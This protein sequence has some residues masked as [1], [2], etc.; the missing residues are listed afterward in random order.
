M[1]SNT[2]LAMNDTPP[3]A[4]SISSQRRRKSRSNSVSSSVVTVK[5][6]ASL[7]SRASASLP[8]TSLSDTAPTT[9]DFAKSSSRPSASRRRSSVAHLAPEVY[10]SYKD[11]NT[12]ASLNRWSQS[13]TS[14]RS[15]GNHVHNGKLALSATI[16]HLPFEQPL[17]S[18][19]R[20]P[21]SPS[22]PSP[23]SSPR[24]RHRT[25]PPPIPTTSAR[26]L[27]PLDTLP[28]LL[29]NVYVPYS[30]STSSMTPSTTSAP[31]TP[32]NQGS[33]D[34]FST[35]PR[36][37]QS[38]L[39]EKTKPHSRNQ[40]GKSLGS[41]PVILSAAERQLS[42]RPPPVPASSSQ[43]ARDAAS[44]IPRSDSREK[45]IYRPMMDTT[46]STFPQEEY[47]MGTPPRVKER[48]D[49]DKKTMLS[50][51]LQKANTAVLLD[52]A[53]N[54]EGAMDA[55]QDACHL[56]QQVMIRSNGEEDRKKLEAIRVTYTNR[57]EELRQLDPSYTSTSG[58]ALPNRPMSNESVDSLGAKSI[59]FNE[60][61]D[62]VIQTAT[63]T[64]IIPD[65]SILPD[66]IPERLSSKRDPRESTFTS[67]M[68]EVERSIPDTDPS[69]FLLNSYAS[70]SLTNRHQAL[71]PR[72]EHT[73]MPPPLSPHPQFA[74][75]FDTTTRDSPDMTSGRRQTSESTRDISR[76]QQ[77]SRENSEESMTWLDTIDES[78]SSCGSSVHSVDS[79]DGTR[80]RKHLHTG[81]NGTE[82]E[83][84]AA[85]DAAVEAAY[86]EGFE[87]YE[88][89]EHSLPRGGSV[90]AAMRK[91]EIAKEKV[92]ELERE[93]AI[94]A[95]S[96]RARELRLGDDDRGGLPAI[97]QSVDYG[98]DIDVDA[99]Q[100]EEMLEEMTKEFML[101]GF[102]FDLQSK[103]ALPRE[104]DSSGISGST[105]N[106][107]RSSKRTT[108]G[109][110][111]TTHSSMSSK[112]AQPPPPD[113]K[114]PPPPPPPSMPQ[115]SANSASTVRNRRLSGK[116]AGQLKIDTSV[117]RNLPAPPHT[118]QLTPKH[119]D[120]DPTIAPHPRSAQPVL[121]HHPPPER[122]APTPNTIDQA[123]R[124]TPPIVPA[125]SPSEPAA[126]SPVASTLTRVQSSEQTMVPS[127]PTSLKGSRGGI[128]ALRKN[129]SSL[130]LRNRALSISSPD[131]SD[132]SGHTPLSSTF[133]NISMRKQSNAVPLTP[134][135]PGFS[136][137]PLISAGIQ[138]FEADIHS[139][140]SPGSPN[141]M[142][143]NAPIP[144]EP[145]PDSYLLRPFWLMRCF[146][147]TIAHPR[148][149][150]LSTKLF[151]PRDVWSVK[152]VKIKATEE[153][154][155]NCDLLTAALMKLGSVDTLD[156]D[157]V[158]EEMQGLEVIL[159]Q[160]QNNLSKKLGSEVGVGGINIF[161]KDA[162]TVG[163]GAATGVDTVEPSANT[164]AAG[165]KSKN[166][167]TSWRKLRSKPSGVGL[168]LLATKDVSKDSLT[169]SSLPMTSLPNI[170]FTKRDISQV[171]FNG[172]NALYMS[173]LAK[174]FD[175]VQVVDR[176]ARQVEDPGL[177][178][179]SQTHVGLELSTRHAAEFFGFYICRFV[180]T[181]LTTMLDKF[182]KR[183]SEWVLV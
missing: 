53:Q 78:G 129:K 145:C 21:S 102:D 163:N 27:P 123:L 10:T 166:Y 7:N 131:G 2:L 182:I 1:Y 139:P 13:T 36:P 90:S 33:S 100:D 67:A 97:R 116:T 128:G 60:N 22:R 52:N 93:E 20:P 76:K 65:S 11:H 153:K 92:L 71:D 140:Y 35:K 57:I 175:A 173:S 32:N 17:R 25:S 91:V 104:S 59:F 88:A 154:I 95:A 99:N 18:P 152:G 143:I 9:H 80:R 114:P 164:K 149:G 133:S 160:V 111:Q 151:V 177:K 119:D 134:M 170:R 115:S 168:S 167:L 110:S 117:H 31:Y 161:F 54:F 147:Q 39:A 132:I 158:L 66:P 98:Y 157:A 37:Q 150:Y 79:Q 30:A 16:T 26:S 87:P 125:P 126:N 77:H 24:R 106:S 121:H 101:D 49:K 43:P 137:E 108:A 42:Q 136:N 5:R 3:P 174:L 47:P 118:E 51:A 86:D 178:H 70:S 45:N 144:L 103:S 156:A 68:R 84:N 162:T 113:K 127:S 48:R 180:L 61:D 124:A 142:A 38:S 34:Y 41:S 69:T 29:P 89:G 55:Y 135:F 105:W 19:P 44:R 172:P 40:T 14:S 85:L 109:Q 75:S 179:S 171:D 183:G 146:Y 138:L 122:Q 28:T 72:M 83:F 181:D 94:K 81:S 107:S 73:Y 130:S 6:S 165:D 74:A 64:R 63:L 56:L 176:V 12:A 46:G 120:F 62:A 141:P 96:L 23:T 169:M 58:K 148:G 4:N 159:D 50:R 82:A 112:L 8:P 155:A 15:S